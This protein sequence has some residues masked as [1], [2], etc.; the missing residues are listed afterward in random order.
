MLRFI[1]EI[2]VLWITAT[3]IM[4]IVESI[5]KQYKNKQKYE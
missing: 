5:W 2:A 4:F 1:L 3:I